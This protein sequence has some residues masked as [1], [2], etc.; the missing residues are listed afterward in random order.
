MDSVFFPEGEKLY[1]FRLNV[2]FLFGKFA[3]GQK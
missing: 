1:I 3:A 2:L